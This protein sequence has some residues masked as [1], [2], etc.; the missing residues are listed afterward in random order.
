MSYCLKSTVGR[1]GGRLKTVKAWQWL[2]FLA[3]QRLHLKLEMGREKKGY[4]CYNSLQQFNRYEC[5]WSDGRRLDVAP[6]WPLP[7]RSYLGRRA[8]D[9]TRETHTV[10][11]TIH[12]LC[13][14]GGRQRRKD[15]PLIR[16]NQTRFGRN[17]GHDREEEAEGEGQVEPYSVVQPKAWHCAWYTIVAQL[18]IVPFLNLW[19]RIQVLPYCSVKFSVWK[20]SPLH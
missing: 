2:M 5:Q 12:M 11:D 14:R 20:N 19:G 3:A 17:N 4:S 10:K 13:G 16:G 9:A 6:Q 1:V 7:L 18:K 8:Q 15:H